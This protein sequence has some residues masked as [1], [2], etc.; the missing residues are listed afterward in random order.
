MFLICYWNKF[1]AEFLI[2]YYL[3][4]EF[5]KIPIYNF[6]FEFLTQI[7]YFILINRNKP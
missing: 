3:F 6:A 5:I 2:T 4:S 1:G 7:F